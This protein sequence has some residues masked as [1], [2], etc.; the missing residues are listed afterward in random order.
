MCSVVRAEAILIAE[1]VQFLRPAIRKDFRELLQFYRKYQNPFE[2]VVRHLYGGYLRANRQPQGMKT[3]NEVVA[4]LI[5]YGY[6]YGWD[7]V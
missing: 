5:A 4:W 1:P 7:G 6:K 2:P 3:Y